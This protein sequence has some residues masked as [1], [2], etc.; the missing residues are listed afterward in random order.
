MPRDDFSQDTKDTL[1]RRV[2]YRCSN[3]NCRAPTSGPHTDASKAVNVGVAAHISAAS[4]GGPRFSAD[5]S[6]GERKSIENA[7]WLCQNCAKLIDSDDKRYTIEYL[8][9]WK[10]LSEEAA[11][12]LLEQPG[13]TDPLAHRASDIELI[14]FY[15]QCL[16]RPAFQDEFAVEMSIEDF[17]KAIVDTLTAINTGCLRS[18]DG[19]VLAQAKGK[20]YLENA[21]WRDRMDVVAELLRALHRRFEIAT[22]SAEIQVGDLRQGNRFY[23]IKDRDLLEWMD[24]TR[25]ELIGVFSQVCSEASIPIL[26]FPTSRRGWYRA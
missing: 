7:I 10:K 26:R 11:Q 15:S 12:L 13:A 9:Q 20:S 23:W 16:D 22:R 18:R 19:V 25:S 1:A 3:P 24:S 6:S 17:D 21:Q 5:L 2:A 14:R 8:E 4:S